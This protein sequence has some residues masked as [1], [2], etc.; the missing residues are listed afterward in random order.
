VFVNRLE[1]QEGINDSQNY[2]VTHVGDIVP[3]IS[4]L[5]D[6]VQSQPNYYI[7]SGNNAIATAADIFV[8]TDPE[9]VTPEISTTQLLANYSAVEDFTSAAHAQY[10]I[11][12]EACDGLIPPAE[13]IKRFIANTNTGSNYNGN[14]LSTAGPRPKS[15]VT[16]SL[17]KGY[18]SKVKGGKVQPHK[19]RKAGTKG[20]PKGKTFKPA[21]NLGHADNKRKAKG[22]K[23]AP[24]RGK[25]NNGKGN[26]GKPSNGKPN[27]GKGAAPPKNAG[28]RKG[29]KI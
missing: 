14:Q 21:R 23:K 4:P 19:A 9:N 7:A 3:N 27:N 29:S 15:A 18:L 22:T 12:I 5:D 26:P 13:V 8:N 28:P 10:I 11:D 24:S 17:I 2:R 6:F 16:G 20:R 25:P 1:A